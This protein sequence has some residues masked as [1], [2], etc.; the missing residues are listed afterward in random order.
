MNYYVSGLAYYTN[1][2]EAKSIAFVVTQASHPC[3][4]E[5]LVVGLT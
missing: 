2:K 1:N 5:G 3:K 4:L